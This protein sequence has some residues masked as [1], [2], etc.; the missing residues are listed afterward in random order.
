MFWQRGV[1]DQVDEELDFHLDMVARELVAKGMSEPDARA[2]A[3]RRFGD[4]AEVRARCRQLGLQHERDVRRA[5][6]LAELRQDVRL[7]FRHL[8]RAPAFAAVAVLTL[9]LAIGANTAIFSAVS[10]VLLRPLPWPAGD[11]LTAV[12]GARAEAPRVLLAYPDLVEYRAR[13]RTLDDLAIARSQGVNLTG[14]D[15]PD[16]LAGSFVSADVL[17]D[18]SATW[19]RSPRAAAPAV[20]PGDG[21]RHDVLDARDL[22]VLGRRVGQLPARLDLAQ[23]RAR[24]APPARPGGAAN[25]R[26]RRPV[27]G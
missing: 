22:L 4:L 15:R 25:R 21:P 16:R 5:E 18:A 24:S 2:E 1:P 26:G 10:A 6:Y 19:P 23:H 17:R 20:A 27:L 13:N 11:R 7:A 12:W 8:R 9:V 14:S 3:K